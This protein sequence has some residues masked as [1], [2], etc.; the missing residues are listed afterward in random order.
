[1]TQRILICGSRNWYDPVLIQKYIKDLAPVVIIQ[2]MAKGADLIARDI[3][4]NLG[5]IYKDF[6]ADWDSLGLAAGPVR[7]Q[8]MLDEGRPDLV[9]AFHDDI[10]NSKGTKDMVRRAQRAGLPVW[11]ISHKGVTKY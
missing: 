8:Q 3:A 9:L 1:M 7:N 6:P 4:M 11:V 5:I 2:G 10:H